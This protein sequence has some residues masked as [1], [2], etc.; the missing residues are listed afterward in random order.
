MGTGSRLDPGRVSLE[1]KS[2]S[3]A[4]CWGEGGVAVKLMPVTRPCAPGDAI[5]DACL[6]DDGKFGSCT[7]DAARQDWSGPVLGCGEDRGRLSKRQEEQ[8]THLRI[9]DER[10]P[11]LP[12]VAAS[13]TGLAIAERIR[14]LVSLGLGISL[15]PRSSATKP[16]YQ[17]ATALIR[18]MLTYSINLQQASA[19]SG[20]AGRGANRR[21]GRDA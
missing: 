21:L 12:A 3:A 11:G 14:E 16:G 19:C 20:C 6:Q 10:V 7:F 1:L 5:C 2:T 18:G 4:V 15:L 13:T 9:D 8:G 17:H